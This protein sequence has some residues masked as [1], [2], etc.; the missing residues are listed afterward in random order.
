[1]QPRSFWVRFGFGDR[2][3]DVCHQLLDIVRAAIGEFPFG[4][5][6][7]PFIGIE[8]RAVGGKMLDV[9][10]GVPL[11]EFLGVVSLVRGR[12]VQQNDQRASQIP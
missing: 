6:Q 10:A 9:Q 3:E 5:D 8:F 11:E 12:I 4:Q 1:M 2:T 7:T